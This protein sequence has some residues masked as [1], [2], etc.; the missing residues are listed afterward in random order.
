MTL[1]QTENK[2]GNLE[3]IYLKG[4]KNTLFIEFNFYCNL[5]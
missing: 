2:I 5:Y 4:P 3:I 1:K